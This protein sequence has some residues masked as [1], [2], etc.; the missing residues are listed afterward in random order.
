MTK[1]KSPYNFVPAPSESEV[2][3]P[4]WADLVSHDIPFEDGESG[5]IELL[6]RAETPIFIRNG[7]A[8]G[9]DTSEFSHV[10]VNGEKKYFIPATSVKGMFR[11]V[12]EIMTRSRMKIVEDDRHAVRQIMRPKDTVIDEGY[13]LTG[14][15]KKKIQAGYL[16]ERNG[17]YLIYSCGNPYKIRYDELD[18]KLDTRFKEYFDKPDLKSEM[19]KKFENRTGKYKYK[20]LIGKRKLEYKFIDHQ[21]D[22]TDNS[23]KEYQKSWVSKFQ[24]LP[25][26]KFA[27]ANDSEAFDGRI[28]CVGQASDYSVS[29]SRKGEY[30]FK[31]KR[32]EVITNESVAINVPDEVMDTFLFVN[33]HNLHDELDDWKFW[34]NRL[35]E[36]VPVFFR[37]QKEGD[38]V[39]VKDFGLTFMYKEPVKY[40]IKEC[41]D[42]S[43]ANNDLAELLFGYTSKKQS[44]KGR[45]MFSHA[46]LRSRIEESEI[47]ELSAAFAAPKSS[48]VPFYLK[49]YGNGKTKEFKTYNFKPQLRGYKRYPVHKNIKKLMTGSD[50]RSTKLKPLPK[51]SEFSLKIR[52]HNLKP[53]EIGA[54]LSTITFHG[55]ED[56]LFHSLGAAKPFGYGK[57]KVS[58][59]RVKTFNHAK[60][61]MEEA[62]LYSYIS[63][64]DCEIKTKIPDWNKSDFIKE[65]LAMSR[66]QN[67]DELLAYMELSDFQEAKRTGAF[68]QDY[69]KYHK[70]GVE[71]DSKCTEFDSFIK[72][73]EDRNENLRKERER[74][75]RIVFQ[76]AL[77]E[78]DRL[79]ATCKFEEAR[80]LANKH[81]DVEVFAEKLKE[82]DD[83]EIKLKAKL[84]WDATD[85]E[86]INQIEEFLTT[87]Q[88][89]N[90][91][92]PEI[93]EAENLLDQLRKQKKDKQISDAATSI[94]EVNYSKGFDAFKKEINKQY[95]QTKGKGFE[96]D[97]VDWLVDMVKEFYMKERNGDIT[98][99]DQKFIKNNNAIGFDNNPWTDISKWLGHEKA[100]EL[101]Q[102]LTGKNK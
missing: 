17:K 35:R 23:G 84:D 3:K 11:N 59:V 36:G 66:E 30:V 46:Y 42:Y 65:L 67:N 74:I 80:L 72:D 99:R 73:R 51:G 76:N 71:I 26:V 58:D 70:E 47:I 2:F 69:T 43:D 95:K 85:K 7:H 83:A 50:A 57:T 32:S 28:V 64:F 89:V 6:L 75:F 44:L 16:V 86:S 62:E 20:T 68:L 98:G 45:V 13:S 15:E 100:F 24:P 94:I 54:L 34:K 1:V 9:Q 53:I 63:A 14:D 18:R 77:R 87:W 52:F 56:L 97:K 27:E 88:N 33:R 31:G 29:T 79:I 48:Y 37:S 38:K 91:S 12:L 8:E 21:L 81:S 78:I 10:V 92:V 96:K 102:Q 5:E 22:E 61:A 19:N 90:V 82:I 40:S 60:R 93:A 55:N 41:L 49:Q 25:Y 4:D 39:V 101:Y